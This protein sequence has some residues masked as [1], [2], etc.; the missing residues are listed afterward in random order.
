MCG[1]TRT[2]HLCFGEGL[3][4][5]IQSAV[6]GL[7]Q[8]SIQKLQV[9][10]ACA[11]SS[12]SSRLNWQSC[13]FLPFPYSQ[14]GYMN[15]NSWWAAYNSSSLGANMT[16][17]PGFPYEK[18]TGHLQK[19]SQW[20]SLFFPSSNSVQ[21]LISRLLSSSD[22]FLH[23]SKPW[24][25]MKTNIKKRKLNPEV[26]KLEVSNTPQSILPSLPQYSPVY[27]YSLLVNTGSLRFPPPPMVKAHQI[28]TRQEEFPGRA[29]N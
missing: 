10:F 6:D 26:K 2:F 1:E 14:Q 23:K 27:W 4:Y 18:Q 25:D 22:L 19:V 29:R 28:N 5:N 24:G 9:I 12:R 3:S 13:G 17:D 20:T 11:E 7:V 15:F 16:G 21:C 8:V